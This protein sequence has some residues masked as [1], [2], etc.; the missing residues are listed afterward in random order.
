MKKI[1]VVNHMLIETPLVSTTCHPS[2][3][4]AVDWS[5]G[6]LSHLANCIRVYYGVTVVWWDVQNDRPGKSLS[7]DNVLRALTRS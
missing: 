5:D 1:F 2:G 6:L 4:G 3:G 7:V